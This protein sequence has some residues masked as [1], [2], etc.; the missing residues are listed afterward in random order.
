[1]NVLFEDFSASDATAWKERLTKDLKGLT[2]EDLSV[3]DRNGLTIHP[4]YTS[5]DREG[6]IPAAVFQHKDWVIC[7]AVKVADE[8][9]A[10]LQALNEL[11]NGASGLCFALDGSANLALLLKDIELRY[12]YTQ[13]KLSGQVSL[14]L[15]QWQEIRHTHQLQGSD[16]TIGFDPIRHYL[17]QGEWNAAAAK[18]DF[19]SVFDQSGQLF[20]D[21]GIY[22]HTGANSSYQ[23]ACCIAHTNEYLN[24]LDEAGKLEALDKVT[25]TLATGTGFFEETGKLRALPVLLA[26]L[27]EQYDIQPNVHLHIE[28]S[29]TYR[30]A[31][32]SYSNLLRDTI[33]GMAGVLG[34]CHSLL[35]H[36]FDQSTTGV[37]E[38]SSRMSRN[39]QLIFKE[40][41][42]LHQVA[43]A[44]S[45]SFYLEKLTEQLAA[46]AWASFQ[47]M[48]QQGGLL[49]CFAKGTL[50]TTIA[51]QAAQWIGEYKTGKRVLIGVNKYVNAKDE[52]KPAT[53]QTIM[54][55]GLE[56]ISLTNELYPS[57]L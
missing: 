35:I 36:P 30:S 5:E 41:S 20:I 10:N 38:F 57:M 39:Q 40:E 3:Q 49:S 9:S 33:A 46:I 52:P 18:E 45:G 13:F 22:D 11:Q 47:A 7:S 1:M 14:F 27:F 29:D 16:Y 2:F 37:N 26:T 8:K 54:S 12:I 51:Q 23:L 19:L 6:P 17:Q 15:S 24:W 44:A 28:T 34:G 21:G 48:E 55:K 53:T 25:L 42:Y 56:L 32:D 43:D 31:F 4:F 50:K